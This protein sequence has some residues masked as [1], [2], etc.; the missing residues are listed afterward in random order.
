MP[1]AAWATIYGLSGFVALSLEI[2][3]F[4]ILDVGIKSSPYTFGH[5]LGVFPESDMQILNLA[6]ARAADQ[7]ESWLDD[8]IENA[9][10]EYNGTVELP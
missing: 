5:V 7:A 3:W 4:R 10:N 8:G 9:M 2:L 6:L 1:L